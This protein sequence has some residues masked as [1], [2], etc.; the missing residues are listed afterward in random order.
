M[1]FCTLCFTSHYSPSAALQPTNA[2][3]LPLQFLLHDPKCHIQHF[4]LLLHVR[5]LQSRRHTRAGIPPRIHHMFPIMMF[6]LI[7]QRLDP[8]LRETPRSRIQR[9]LLRPHDGL[10]I[11]IQV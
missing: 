1:L 3:L 4:Q 10:R 8:G 5:S 7:Q 9:F 2:P 6:R 11:G